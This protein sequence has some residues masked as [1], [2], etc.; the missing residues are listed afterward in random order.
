MKFFII[1]FLLGLVQIVLLKFLLQSITKQKGFLSFL[2]FAAKFALYAYAIFEF[3]SKYVSYLTYCAFGFIIGTVVT[4]FTVF[5]YQT[6]V[7]KQ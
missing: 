3:L 4:A 5:I 7:K 6:F 1:S 2:L